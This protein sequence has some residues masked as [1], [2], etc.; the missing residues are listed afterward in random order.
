MG[1]QSGEHGVRWADFEVLR[2][3]HP[4]DPLAKEFHATTP[5]YSWLSLQDHYCYV[6][7]YV[8]GRDRDRPSARAC[9]SSAHAV[10]RMLPWHRG[11]KDSKCLA[12]GP[13]EPAVHIRR[14]CACATGMHNRI[15]CG[16]PR[17]RASFVRQNPPVQV[18]A[19]CS[20]CAVIL[21]ATS[22]R[23]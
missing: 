13:T 18:I 2:D 14:Y 5:A 9:D 4:D 6:A 12:C 21:Q 15:Q 22:R 1:H 16:C 8:V 20:S 3:S 19:W 7:S 11:L 23:H 10:M 17:L